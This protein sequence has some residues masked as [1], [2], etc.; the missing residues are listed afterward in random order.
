MKFKKILIIIPLLLCCAWTSN[1][2]VEYDG[3]KFKEVI[4]Y[5]F[6]DDLRNIAKE[7]DKMEEGEFFE[8]ELLSEDIHANSSKVYDKRISDDY[9]TVTL[10][11]EY[12][13]FGEFGTSYQ[14][15][16]CYEKRNLVKKASKYIIDLSGEYYCNNFE[17]FN[18]KTSSI[19]VSDSNANPYYTE[20]GIYRWVNLENNNNIHIVLKDNSNL[21]NLIYVV[22]IV[23]VLVVAILIINNKRKQANRM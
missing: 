15:A 14:I 7:Y 9:R 12:K 19:N 11:A 10:T 3:R 21:F 1:Y 2:T 4:E 6:E 23:L 8:V 13:S 18:I 16:N 20:D 22:P 17:T 5:K